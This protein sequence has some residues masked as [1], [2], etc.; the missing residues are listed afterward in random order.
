[1]ELMREA[2]VIDAETDRPITG[3][4]AA[5]T[6]Q[7]P[8]DAETDRPVTGHVAVDT[9]H[10][11]IGAETDRPITGSVAADTDQSPAVQQSLHTIDDLAALN[12]LDEVMIF[13]YYTHRVSE[14]DTDL[15]SH[16][17]LDTH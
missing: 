12:K 7:S 3:S 16:Y 17:N 1:M 11:P 9:D 5:D 2:E 15:L 4:V 10:S 13:F 14:N 8:V 6:D